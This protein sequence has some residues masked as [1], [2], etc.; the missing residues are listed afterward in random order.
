MIA[1]LGIYTPTQIDTA[2]EQKLEASDLAGLASESYV[3]TAVSG[4]LSASDITSGTITPGTGDI[5]FD[6][7]GGGGTEQITDQSDGVVVKNSSGG[8]GYLYASR[9]LHIGGTSGATHVG[10]IA[11]VNAG[12]GFTSAA[13]TAS[14]SLDVHFARVSSSEMELVASDGSTVAKLTCIPNLSPITKAALLSL[15]ASTDAGMYRV[16]DESNKPV[17]PDGSDF[18]YL[19]DNTVVS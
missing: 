13:V 17:Y 1:A 3:D 14:S 10:L 16:T 12:I 11:A 7:L 8:N 5:D 18:R 6:N 4:K 9:L 2:L 15:T 19:T